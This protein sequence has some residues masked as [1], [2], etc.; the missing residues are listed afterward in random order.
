MEAPTPSPERRSGT[1]TQRT[2]APA[3]TQPPGDASATSFLERARLRRRLAYL[4]RRRE[5][6][7]RELGSLVLESHRQGRENAAVDAQL[8]AL[9][10]LDDERER[11]ERALGERRELALLREP[12]ITSC[13]QCSTI[14]DSSARFCPGCGQRRPVAP[15]SAS[16]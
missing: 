16:T 14:H 3:P 12:G 2:A 15:R 6:A 11:L 10:A 8:G 4:G 7:L 1:V 13:P 9:A 5:L